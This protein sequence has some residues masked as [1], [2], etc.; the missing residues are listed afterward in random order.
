[1]EGEADRTRLEPPRL[2]KVAALTVRKGE[3]MV[4]TDAGRPERAG[5]YSAANGSGQSFL[6]WSYRYG[7]EHQ[8][9]W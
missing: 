3:K 7:S 2:F 4:L 6:S 8:Q 1:M 9:T 5:A